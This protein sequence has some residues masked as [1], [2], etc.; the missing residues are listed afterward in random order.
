MKIC[1]ESVRLWLDRHE[2]T[3][4]WLWFAALWLA[5]L[6]AVSLMAYPVKMLVRFAS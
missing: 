1:I 4:Q 3:R 5:G 2:K 6:A